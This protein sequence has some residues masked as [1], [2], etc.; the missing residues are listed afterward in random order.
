M[1]TTGKNQA[2][3]YYEILCV[4]ACMRNNS[5]QFYWTCV[6]ACKRDSIKIHVRKILQ[7]DKLQASLLFIKLKQNPSKLEETTG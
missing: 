5:A 7:R 1:N 3:I 4:H 2:V 6:V